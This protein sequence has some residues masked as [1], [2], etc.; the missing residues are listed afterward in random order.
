MELRRAETGVAG[1]TQVGRD[2]DDDVEVVECRAGG[3]KR[4]RGWLLLVLWLVLS[5]LVLWLSPLLVRLLVLWLQLR[6][7]RLLLLWLL[8]RL[9]LR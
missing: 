8:V 4:P 3:G 6:L 1:G 5:L 2:A 9:L 7:V